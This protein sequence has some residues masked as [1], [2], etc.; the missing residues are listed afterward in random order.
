MVWPRRRPLLY[1]T[2]SLVIDIISKK[3]KKS[4]KKHIL[5][6]AGAGA[7]ADAGAVA[8]AGVVAA[9][10]AAVSMCRGVLEWWR[11]LLVRLLVLV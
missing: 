5:A 8:G 7:V 11:G 6:G 3:Q 9:V 2:C 1:H 10:A 4:R